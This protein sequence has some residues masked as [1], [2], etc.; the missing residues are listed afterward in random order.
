MVSNQVRFVGQDEIVDV[1][2]LALRFK[3]VKNLLAPSLLLGM[4]TLKWQG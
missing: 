3:I 2:D 1:G 4:T